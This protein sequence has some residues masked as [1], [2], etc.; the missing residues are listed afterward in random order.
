MSDTNIKTCPMCGGEFAQPAY[1]GDGRCGRC[2]YRAPVTKIKIVPS[3]P[4]TE[5]GIYPLR[6]PWSH[7][8]RL[9]LV[10]WARC[11]GTAKGRYLG[12]RITG[13]S[14]VHNVGH[15]SQKLCAWGQ[16]LELEE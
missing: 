8:W 11:P 7:K 4:P 5:P 16:R 12:Y 6:L 9:V 13:E 15:L 10:D 3:G 1:Q 14:T 2:A